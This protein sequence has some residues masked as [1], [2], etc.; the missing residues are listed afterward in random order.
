M[1]DLAFYGRRLFGRH[2]RSKSETAVLDAWH[3]YL[4]H[5]GTKYEQ[6]EFQ[7]WLAKGEELFVNLLSALATDVGFRFDRVQLKKGA[8]SPMAQGELE[9]E[10]RQLRKR[11]IDVLSG[12]SPVKMEVTALPLDEGLAKAQIDL[13]AKLAAAL[14]GRGRLSVELKTGADH[15]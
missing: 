3:E 15:A 12:A 7:L 5:L 14:D 11:A 8:Y 13:Q 2:R 9:E 4:D 10:Q 1:I 6:P